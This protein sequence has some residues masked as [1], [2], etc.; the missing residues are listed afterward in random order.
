MAMF[1]KA[2]ASLEPIPNKARS[3]IGDTGNISGV[4]RRVAIHVCD[5]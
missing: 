1:L 4:T 2:H 3:R 5:L